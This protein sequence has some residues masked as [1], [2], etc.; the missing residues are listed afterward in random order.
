MINNRPLRCAIVTLVVIAL[1]LPI[2]ACV[3]VAMS[4]LLGS[5][6]DPVG[7]TVLKWI[8]LGLGI[9]WVIVLIAMLIAVAVCTLVEERETTKFPNENERD[10]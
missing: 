7:G 1:L 8:A 10:E 6:G 5:M 9:V 2:A 3:V 4:A